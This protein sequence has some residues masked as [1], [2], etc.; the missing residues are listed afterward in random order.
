MSVE[1]PTIKLAVTDVEIEKCGIDPGLYMRALASR[2]A[3]EAKQVATMIEY[4]H[5][6]A[7]KIH[8]ATVYLKAQNADRFP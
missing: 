7:A 5:D 6:E 2:K 1:L 3:L 4:F 8:R